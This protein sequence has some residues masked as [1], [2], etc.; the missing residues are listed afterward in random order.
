[1]K[2]PF[3]IHTDGSDSEWDRMHPWQRK[4]SLVFMLCLI[5]WGTPVYE[6]MLGMSLYSGII[7]PV[8]FIIGLISG[9]LSGVIPI[10]IKSLSR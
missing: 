7:M 5:L 8:A 10:I 2:E 3:G 9:I 4:L 1:M 6:S